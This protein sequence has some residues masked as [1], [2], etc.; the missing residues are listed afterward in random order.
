[1]PT[2]IFVDA[3]FFLRR[4]PK[5]Y[6]DIDASNAALVAKTLHEMVLAHVAERDD[7]PRRDLSRIFVYDCPPLD[8]KAEQ[9]MSSQP[10]DFSQ[11][12]DAIFRRQFHEALKLKRKVVLRLGRLQD[13]GWKVKFSNL[14][15][16][17]DSEQDTVELT[18]EDFEYDVRPKGIEMRVGLDIASVAYKKQVD[19]I[20]LVAGG[21]A[22]N[23][24]FVPAAK[25]ARREGIDFILDPMRTAISREM[26]EHIDGLHSTC[27]HNKLSL[28]N[29]SDITGSTVSKLRVV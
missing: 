10:I 24:D 20:V 23:I 28:K 27:P 12:E 11:K 17:L 26:R 5:V 29:K 16:H 6:H 2:A 9:P 4:F 15:K 25:L 22:S 13:F 7:S 19:Q 3:N 18:D 8:K 1:M 14:K 21:L